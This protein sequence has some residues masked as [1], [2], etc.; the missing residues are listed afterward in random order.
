MSYTLGL[1]LRNSNKD[2]T[3]SNYLFESVKLNKNR[4]ID[5]YKYTGYSIGFDSRSEFLFTDGSHGKKV[6]IFRAHMRS[7]VHVE[8]KGKDILILDEGPTQ[9]LDDT[10]LAAEAK[11]PSNF[12]QSGK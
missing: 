6:I 5:K 8:N 7:S 11:Y 4:N 10:A 12:T 3:L 9:G 2:F 1:Q